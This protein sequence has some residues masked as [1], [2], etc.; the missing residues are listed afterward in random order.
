M[1]YDSPMACLRCGSPWGRIEGNVLICGRCPY[2]HTI[3]LKP[4]YEDLEKRVKFL[5]A[6]IRRTESQN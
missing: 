6:E 1:E 3:P 5:E 2:H 4:S